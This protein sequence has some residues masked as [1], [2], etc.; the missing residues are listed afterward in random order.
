MKH[1][2]I[3]GAG[4]RGLYALESLFT[5]LN[6][7]PIEACIQVTLFEPFKYPGAGWVWNPLQTKSNW[8]NITERDL[9]HLQGRPAITIEDHK[10]PAFPS[11]TEWAL[12]EEQY[13]EPTHPDKFPPRATIGKYLNKRFNTI[14][15][16]LIQAGVLTIVK[17]TVT[18]LSYSAP[19]FTAITPTQSITNID[20]T[21]LTL[22]HQD[23][24]L[25]SQLKEWKTHVSKT[26]SSILFTEAYPVEKIITANITTNSIVAF[27]G[28]GLAM[29]DQ[30]RALT[31]QR[32]AHF[33]MLDTE[34]KQVIFH[35][36]KKHSQRFVP[37][38][39]DGLPMVPK[40]ISKAIDTWFIPSD[41][42][43][44]VFAKTIQQ[45]AHGDHTANNYYFL[46]EAMAQVVAP[47][48]LNLG[49]KGITHDLSEEEIYFLTINYLNNKSL[50]HHLLLDL[51]TPVL[52]MMKQQVAMAV[53]KQ[54]ISLDYLIGQVWRHCQPYMYKEFS[55]A[56]IADEV[57]AQVIALDEASKR[58]SYGPPVESM[59]Q[60]IALAQSGILDLNFLNNP[61]ID[62]TENGW[63]LNHNNH[64]VTADVMINA[65]L[66]A[67]KLLA[68]ATPI[69]KNLLNDKMIAPKH[70]DLGIH[71]GKDGYVRATGSKNVIPLAVLGRLSKGSTMG[72]DAILACFGPSTQAWAERSIELMKI[73][74]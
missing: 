53:G 2:A 27:R 42:A 50:K 29:I 54:M 15:T 37:F 52:S 20:E 32:G 24:E 19:Y 72:I 14:A 57:I 3:I 71:T 1:Y 12:K 40:P 41:K 47:L 67:P 31:L 44:K 16:V 61:A 25:S 30:I 66:D 58:Y 38:S 62:C 39:L 49:T 70:S 5:A 22:G 28:F 17:E 23:T 43:L 55:Y 10:I 7:S 21:L 45:A 68:V 34:T 8:L 73:E 9:Q 33:E 48:Y 36:S 11:Y 51:H 4:P 60:L 69:I 74:K 65:V 59:Q 63:K 46:L 6:N 64:E 26:S 13:S 56:T 35:G 18:K